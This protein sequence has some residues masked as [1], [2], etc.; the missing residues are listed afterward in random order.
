MPLSRRAVLTVGGLASGALADEPPPACP[1][2]V[3]VITPGG[4][5]LHAIQ[6]GWVRV[7]QRHRRLGFPAALRLPA[8]ILDS[9]WTGWL[10]ILA[11]AIEHPEGLIIV[12]TGETARVAEPGWFDCSPGDAFFYTRN[13]RFAV[14]DGD[15]IGPQL[16]RIG[17][18]PAAARWVAMT[19]L[20]SDHTGGMA[21]FPHS[22]FLVSRADA[23]GHLGTLRCRI[24]EGLRRTAI[25]HVGPAVG[26]FSASHAITR[27]GDVRL[28]P[29]PGHS[30]AHQSVLVSEG[31]LH[32]LFA[33]DAAF[34]L[35]QVLDDEVAGIVANVSAARLTLATLRRQ[36]ERAA[37]VLLPA[38]DAGSAERLR[39]S[40]LP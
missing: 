22:E 24:P 16:R 18:D 37:T 5:R 38:H 2:P 23:T 1:P 12:D 25:E 13:L 4:L 33:G 17:L 21:Y 20:H 7:K 9:R 28:V 15:E 31:E 32:W 11:Y 14:A 34:D 26:A 36:L 29:T 27:A 8:I 19:H 39:L 30:P 10:P 3:S 35:R 6:T 40:V